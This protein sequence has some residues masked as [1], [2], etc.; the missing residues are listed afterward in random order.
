[1]PS[2]KELREQAEKL[3]KQANEQLAVERAEG[4]RKAKEIIEEY[5]LT[6]YDLGLVRTQQVSPKKDPKKKTFAVKR[7]SP[8]RPPRY[9]DPETGQTWSGFGHQPRWIVGNRDD[10]LIEPQQQKPEKVA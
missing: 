4:I 6:A 10:Y 9:R 1:M 7:P 5:G 2:Y 8:P 3:L